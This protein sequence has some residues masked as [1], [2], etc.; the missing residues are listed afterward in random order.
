MSK[1]LIN[2]FSNF[3]PS[4][5][6][7]GYRFLKLSKGQLEV[8]D[9]KNA[10][11]LEVWDVHNKHSYYDVKGNKRTIVLY[12]EGFKVIPLSK[13]KMSYIE[14]QQLGTDVSSVILPTRE[15]VSNVVVN[16][17]AMENY[18]YA[19]GAL[20]GQI[21]KSLIQ[22]GEYIKKQTPD[23]YVKIW[24]G[25]NDNIYDSRYYTYVPE[26]EIPEGY[27]QLDEKEDVYAP[28]DSKNVIAIYEDSETG[29][30]YHVSLAQAAEEY[31]YS[32]YSNVYWYSCNCYE[33][34]VKFYPDGKFDTMSIPEEELDVLNVDLE[35]QVGDGYLVTDEALEQAVEYNLPEGFTDQ[36]YDYH[37]FDNYEPLNLE[38]EDDE[39]YYGFEIE[40]EGN[41]KNS[42]LIDNDGI[43]H[44]ER[45]S[46]LRTGFEMVSQPMSWGY[47]T[48]G[49][50]KTFLKDLFEELKNN[51]QT[52]DKES[53]CGLH[54]HVS[55]E[56]FETDDSVERA[57]AIVAG[58]KDNFEKLA[59]RKQNSYCGYLKVDGIK[60]KKKDIKKQFHGRYVAVNDTNDDTIEFRMFQ[61]T[62]DYNTLMASI[63]LVRNIIALANSD[64]KAI[65]FKELLS[66]GEYLKEYASKFKLKLYDVLDFSEW[67]NELD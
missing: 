44:C 32:D 2:S 23:G 24:N 9:A 14:R 58:F 11:Y 57:K 31:F 4:D 8:V 39:I 21:A 54:I 50:T 34:I 27:I 1:I 33:V 7:L 17:K 15:V 28:A 43:L 35:R 12:P 55:V 29:P 62:L 56:A 64:K 25:E 16:W 47:L 13:T 19:H 59:R 65:Q 6:I 66:E 30:I 41:L 60:V 53:T 45:D 37:N 26:D 63:E 22:N 61:S 5:D 48:S 40:T 49:K 38:D 42:Y 10:K 18:H 20:S 51:G 36:V 67:E 3:T 52:A 46:S